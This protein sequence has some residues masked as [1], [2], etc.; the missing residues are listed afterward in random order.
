MRWKERLTTAAI[1]TC[2]C[3]SARAGT[4]EDV[5]AR[6]ASCDRVNATAEARYQC[7]IKAT[8]RKCRGDLT[9]NIRNFYSP[10]VQKRWFLCLSQC[11]GAGLLSR[12]VGECST[13][14]GPAPQSVHQ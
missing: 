1:A 9:R 6:F 10:L 8:P 7:R 5:Q 12:T 11:D 4:V 13:R 2:V 14:S 3:L